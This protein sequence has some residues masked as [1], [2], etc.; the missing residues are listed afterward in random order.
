[1]SVI[2]DPATTYW[3][4]MAGGTDLAYKGGYAAG[5]TYNDGDIVIGSDG[6]AYICVQD[7][8][9][10]TPPVSWLGTTP[11]LADTTWHTVGAAGEPIYQ[12]SWASYGAPFS[13]ARF[14]RYAD[15][16]VEIQG[17]IKRASEPAANSPIFTLPVGYRP[18]YQLIFTQACAGGACRF[19]IT[20]AGIV[21][22]GGEKTSGANLG[23]YT[24]LSNMQFLA[25]A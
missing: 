18:V 20:T 25:E 12:D 22:Y 4:P 6:I 1:M 2:P 15:G 19:D 9:L 3:V 21:Q 8:T 17:L 24:S 14:R 7:G 11:Y 16:I 5:V 13:A 23:P 10:N